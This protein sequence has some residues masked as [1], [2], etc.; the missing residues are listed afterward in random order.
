MKIN[1]KFLVLLLLTT[2]AITGIISCQKEN[3]VTTNTPPLGKQGVLVYLNDDPVSNLQ[4]VLI[5]VRYIEVKIDTGMTHHD[6]N[7]YENDDNGDDDHHDYDQYGKWDTISITPRIYDLLKLKNGVDTLMANSFA[8]AGKITKMRITLGS[9]NSVWTDST[10]NYPLPICD[11]NPYVYVRVTSNAIETLSSGESK[12]KIDFDVA[13]SIEFENG[14]YCLKPQLKSYSDKNCAKIEGQVK[15]AEAHARIMA[16]NATDT[17]YAIP[18]DD[19]EFKI[20]GLKPATYSILYKA[21]A[22][23]MDSVINNINVLAG[24]EMKMQQVTLHQ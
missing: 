23:F 5:D 4:K 22:P 10:H 3:S 12:I 7:F 2:T 8:Y 15:P 21:T 11:N 13:K 24:Q 14:H 20:S 6:D 19:G 16:Y 9:N 17:A 18:E 1:N